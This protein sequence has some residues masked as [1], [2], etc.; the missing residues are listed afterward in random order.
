MTQCGSCAA[1]E[2]ECSVHIAVGQM[3]DGLEAEN[4]LA[5]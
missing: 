1:R 5:A 4:D 2:I 3:M